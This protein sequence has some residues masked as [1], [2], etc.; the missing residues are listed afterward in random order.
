MLRGNLGL[1]WAQEPLRRGIQE[2][3]KTDTF[4]KG[5][6]VVCD[7]AGSFKLKDSENPGSKGMAKTP[8]GA[9]RA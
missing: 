5:D 1:C 8:S 9:K 6:K 4:K 7:R 3:F 2:T